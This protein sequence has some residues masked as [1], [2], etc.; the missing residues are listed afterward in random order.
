MSSSGWVSDI[1]VGA[2]GS[3]VN[4][5][6]LIAVNVV[7]FLAFLS[8]VFLLITVQDQTDIVP[9]IIV[10]IFFALGELHWA[11]GAYICMASC[12]E[13]GPCCRLAAR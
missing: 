5:T 6:T 2:L 10:L 11:L 12:M 7:T 8:L 9:H 4:L 1:V 3:G 13:F